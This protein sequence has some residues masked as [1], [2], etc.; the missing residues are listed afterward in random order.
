LRIPPS[1]GSASGVLNNPLG[2]NRMYVHLEEELSYPKWWDALRAGRV[3]VTNGPLLRVRA[4]GQVPGHVFS[5]AGE[6]LEIAVEAALTTRDAIPAL[7]V[8]KNG[9]VERRV[10]YEEWAETG[11]L[12]RIRFESSGWFLVRAIAANPETFRFTSTGP[13]YVEIG[14]ARRR[15]SKSSAQFFRDWVRERS[16][17]LELPDTGRRAEVLQHH[18]SAERFWEDVLA[19][20]NAE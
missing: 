1:A 17:R 4:N 15:I 8:I 9:Q 2:Y 7:E 18:A 5:S 6:A 20:A 16:Q 12:G 3:F 10:P 13:Y 14:T 19:R 11:T